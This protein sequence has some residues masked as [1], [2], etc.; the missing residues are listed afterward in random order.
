LL[1]DEPVAGLSMEETFLT[2]ELIKGMQ[3]DGL[4]IM[5]VEHDMKF[6]RQIATR[7]TVLHGGRVFAD[8]MTGEVL[9]REDVA[10]IYLGKS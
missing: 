1:L 5:V 9:S 7:V 6:V 2:G 4:T 3:E 10:D 8:G